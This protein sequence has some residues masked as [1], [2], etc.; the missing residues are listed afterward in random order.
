MK[1]TCCRKKT[2]D[3]KGE[4]KVNFKTSKSCCVESHVRVRL[5]TVRVCRSY[6]AGSGFAGI[7]G[8]EKEE[9]DEKFK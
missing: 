6:K 1:R 7:L 9:I 4:K 3:R 5:K 8:N 2:H